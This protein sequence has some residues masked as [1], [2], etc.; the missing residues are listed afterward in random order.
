MS[1]FSEDNS[2][3]ARGRA[4]EARPINHAGGYH[5]EGHHA[6]YGYH[7]NAEAAALGA[8]AVGGVGVGGVVDTT[9]YPLPLVQPTTQI[10][11]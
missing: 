3:I 5:G 8:A 10:P 7:G 11:Q 6:G 2:L 4:G 1:S 9:T